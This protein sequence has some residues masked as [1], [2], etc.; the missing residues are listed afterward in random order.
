MKQIDPIRVTVFE[1]H[2]GKLNIEFTDAGKKH[3]SGT[4]DGCDLRYLS[5]KTSSYCE[6]RKSRAEPTQFTCFNL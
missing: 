3:G 5:N 4:A 1:K 6:L 2:T